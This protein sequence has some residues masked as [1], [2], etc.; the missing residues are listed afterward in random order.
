MVLPSI[1]GDMEGS[2]SAFMF[3]SGESGSAYLG[4]DLLVAVDDRTTLALSEL[5]RRSYIYVD[6]GRLPTGH[7]Q[8]D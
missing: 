2:E 4:I 7:E 8:H 1:H 6:P 5:P 3:F